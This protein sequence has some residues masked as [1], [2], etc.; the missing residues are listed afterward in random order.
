MSCTA[1]EGV[2]REAEIFFSVI[3]GN[4]FIDKSFFN[5]HFTRFTCQYSRMR[6]AYSPVCSRL[7]ST[8]SSHSRQ[9]AY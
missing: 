6:P 5:A 3:A 7:S 4:V 8:S 1:I 9:V 2:A